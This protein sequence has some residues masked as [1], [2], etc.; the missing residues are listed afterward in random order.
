MIIA[1]PILYYISDKEP[2][3][4]AFLDTVTDTF[5]SFQGV[6]V[7]DSWDDLQ[8]WCN[9]PQMLE[10]LRGL[11][12]NWFFDNPSSST[13]LA[14]RDLLFAVY[15]ASNNREA[16]ISSQGQALDGYSELANYR[17]II[18][19]WIAALDEGHG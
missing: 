1:V 17:Q 3:H 16:L 4:L 7:F 9:R 6:E 5:L 18:S 12:P 2:S 13:D 11:C 19:E 10:R 14:R 8:G 15:R